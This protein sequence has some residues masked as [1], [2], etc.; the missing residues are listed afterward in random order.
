MCRDVALVFW[1]VV[2]V[3]FPSGTAEN[4]KSTI[5]LKVSRHAPRQNK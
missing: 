4:K 5:L 1:A 3:G 2:M